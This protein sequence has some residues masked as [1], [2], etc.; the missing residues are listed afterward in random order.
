MD[1]F[2]ATFRKQFFNLPLSHTKFSTEIKTGHLTGILINKFPRAIFRITDYSGKML[3]NCQRRIESRELGAVLE[4]HI[5]DAE[6]RI[7]EKEIRLVSSNA[8]FQ[9]ISNPGLH[10]KL[11]SECLVHN[12]FYLFSGFHPHNFFELNELLQMP[13]FNF[14]TKFGMTQ[15]EIKKLLSESGME[16]IHFSNAKWIKSYPSLLKFL[17]ILKKSGANSTA[18]PIPSVSQ[19]KFLE[20]EY[21]DRFSNG[22]EVR[23]TWQPWF[24]LAQKK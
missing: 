10:F 23:V 14:S 4:F 24:C 9:W 17:E 16:I 3:K 21:K 11:I 19:L 20:K 1:Y 6:T 7:Q 5:Q 8:L 18:M 15:R 13:P 12:G 22:N 2:H